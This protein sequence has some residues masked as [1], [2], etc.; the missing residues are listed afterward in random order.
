MRSKVFRRENILA[1]VPLLFSF[2][3]YFI[4]N[5]APRWALTFQGVSESFESAIGFCS[6]WWI[7]FV[8]PYIL[9]LQLRKKNIVGM[10]RWLHI[11]LSVIFVA[12]FYWLFFEKVGIIPGWHTTIE[13]F[14]LHFGNTT[15]SVLNFM[16]VSGFIVQLSFIF[17]FA[18]M[19]KKS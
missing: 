12:I 4:K 13:P 14:N 5:D 2:Y 7:V 19:K 15:I 11:I 9:H 3:I 1:L 10:M 18:L 16:L 8:V 6:I 17:F